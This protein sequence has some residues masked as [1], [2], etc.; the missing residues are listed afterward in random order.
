MF[1]RTL[2]AIIPVLVLTFS[3]GFPVIAADTGA[4][5]ATVTVQNISL[6][7]ADGTVSYGIMPVSTTKSTIVADLNDLQTVTNNGN[8]TEDFNIKGQ[9]TAAWTLGGAAGVDT[10]THKFCTA[11]CGTPPTNY[12]ALTTNYATLGTA[13][14]TSG[15]KTFDLQLGTPTST[16]TFTS[17]SVDVTVQAVAN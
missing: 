16:A 10:Y 1:K 4:V 6:T 11:T 3:F 8:V 7:V 9:H 5:T 2:N 14:A 13:I 17:Q 15:T 12:T